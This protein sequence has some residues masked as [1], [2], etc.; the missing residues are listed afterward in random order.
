MR[1]KSAG[2]CLFAF[3]LLTLLLTAAPL[4][5]AESRTV[6]VGWF[7]FSG[8]QELD[9]DGRP[10]GYN[11]EYLTE[12]SKYTGWKYEFVKC[13]WPDGMKMLERG[14]VDIL[15][16]MYKTK[17]RDKKYAYPQLDCGTTSISLFVRS[18]SPI[19]PYDFA[20]FNNM[21]VACCMATNNDEELLKFAEA[22]GFKVNI[23]NY[24]KK[25]DLIA[26]VESGAV[27][28]GV[29][30]SQ[31]TKGDIKVVAGFFPSSFYF[32]TTKGNMEVLS[33]LNSAI[34][35]IKVENNYYDKD[36]ALKYDQSNKPDFI[37]KLKRL[38]VL[39]V[40]LTAL[41]L[42]VMV[43][44]LAVFSINKAKSVKIV[45]KLLYHDS[46]TGLYN[47]YGFEKK[48]RAI[49]SHSSPENRYAIV[50]LDISEFHQY[51]EFNGI[52][53]GDNLLRIVGSTAVSMLGADELC[54][55]Y[56]ADDFV[57]LMRIRGDDLRVRITEWDSL[58]RSSVKNYSMR[59]VY[60]VYAVQDR[61]SAV[62]FM[63]DRALF[64]L[65]TAHVSNSDSIN[66]NF[67][68]DNS[69]A[70]QLENLA[71]LSSADAAF[72]NGEF[73]VYYQ[74]KYYAVSETV[75]GAEA[76]VRWK[77]ADGSLIPPIKFIELFEKNGMIA[78][79]DFYVFEKVCK[80]IADRISKGLRTAPISVNF[81]R[82][83][84]LDPSFP[85]R[86][87]GIAEKYNI[88]RDMLEIELTESSFTLDAAILA[89]MMNKL[90]SHGFK[91]AID[92]FGSGYS[93]LG[94]LKDIKADTLKM[95][96]SF[97]IGFER[98]GRVGTIMTSVL[99]MAKRLELP[100]VVEGVE[101]KAQADFI[102]SVGGDMIQGYYYSKPVPEDVWNNMLDTCASPGPSNSCEGLS[103]EDV[104][105]LMGDSSLV[106]LLLKGLCA[107]FGLYEYAD[108]KLDVMRVNEGY[109]KIMGVTAESMDSYADDVI[110]RVVPEDRDTFKNAL[111]SAI[112]T[113][114]PV[115]VNFRR[116]G[117]SG[118]I[119]YLEG[120][121]L[122]INNSQPAPI[123]CITFHAANSREESRNF[124]SDA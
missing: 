106:N 74:P 84:I 31:I 67:Y 96:L 28:A 49:L 36:L 37:V 59:L 33:G 53:A 52:D 61:N 78:R 46:L 90:H 11:Y 109:R 97:L 120:T 110:Q 88:P 24:D 64:A 102:K 41:I 2:L 19:K 51:N 56:S 87:D 116:I 48:A 13:T 8:Y 81:S 1:V 111:K 83:H 71:L 14:E 99:H 3:L 72:R 75:A 65:K 66:I 104:G 32:V 103:H 108:G 119:I 94:I 69:Y 112:S 50:A 101:T 30:G 25:P 107:G 68:D 10:C 58:F 79:L 118:N 92:D 85:E 27:D 43:I 29:A 7:P 115:A 44:A 9:E 47:K 12:I 35:A 89:D 42:L 80:S 20:S 34:N 62:Q 91:V 82:A 22:N 95:D 113:G 57:L 5:G 105:I 17:G 21:T 100:V 121:I 4:C 39:V 73:L 114:E 98:G 45:Q 60:G 124:R 86:A 16:C 76:L 123:V 6:R 63:Y 77:K 117:D 122:L 40:L 54:A 26:A 70:E 55:R 15:G 18:D 93:S 23:V 38:P